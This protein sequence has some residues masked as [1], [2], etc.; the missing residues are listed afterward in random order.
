MNEENNA[1]IRRVCETLFDTYTQVAANDVDELQRLIDPRG[2]TKG[3][4]HQ[5]NVRY[6]HCPQA[7]AALDVLVSAH[8]TYI[9]PSGQKWFSLKSRLNQLTPYGK[10]NKISDWYN[11][12]T[13]ITN[14][15]L[16]DSNFYTT[17]QEVYTDRCLGGTGACYIGGDETKPLH[18]VHVPLGSFAIAE[19]A[20]GT[21]NMLVRKFRYTPQQ[22]AS[23]WGLENLPE[24]VREAYSDLQRR[25]TEK[26]EFVHLV[27]PRED[28]IKGA[29]DIPEE[30][31]EYEGIYADTRNYHVI[32]REGYFEF[33]YLVTRFLKGNDSA[34]G[35]APGLGV[36]PIIRQLM[37]LERL[38]DTQAE[39]ATFPRVLQLAGQ[40]R[41][42]D[43]RAG[44]IT[45]ITPDEA[46]LGYPREW[47]TQGRYDIGLDRI[48]AKVEI[49]NQA[50]YVNMLN[51]ISSVDRQMTAT[52]INARESEKV[53][54]FSPSFTLFIA[55][56]R[57]AMRRII[58]ILY[59]KG[60]LPKEGMPDELFQVDSNGNICVMNPN[61]SYLGKIAQAIERVQRRGIDQ[62]LET[63]IGYTQ[64]TGDGSM[65]QALQPRQIARYVVE[66]SGAPYDILR[67]DVELEAMDAQ[68][69]QM[70]M[71]QLEAEQQ[72]MQMEAADKGASAIQKL[73]K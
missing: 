2:Y 67:T 47:G 19:D 27:R 7:K 39:V 73:S 55:D 17:L 46:S 57:P 71:A 59:R 70:Q 58:S 41:Q 38:L 20:H 13:E 66:A 26:I 10:K 61:V 48:K 34:Y 31:R 72:Q 21:V 52:E 3:K 6:R 64:A 45:T 43:M 1:E 33:P 37:K 49:I 40:N 28:G 69:A 56:F 29:Q 36:I 22:A 35:V 50:Y 65:L 42:V 11:K 16:S 60:L 51:A 23:Q 63:I 44:G 4:L 68:A 54:A 9:S 8:S 53:L 12:C 25:Y 18:F 5:E 62:A 14:N 30:M 15:E 32:Q 24:H